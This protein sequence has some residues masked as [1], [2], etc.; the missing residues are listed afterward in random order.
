M[1]HCRV[2]MQDS[3]SLLFLLSFLSFSFSL[4]LSTI[5]IDIAKMIVL[6]LEGSANKIGIGIISDTT[7]L[8]NVRRTF[9]PP[10]GQGFLPKETAAHH[11]AH[12]LALI[13]AALQEAKI[14][15]T[16]ID[17]I[18]YTKGKSRN[19]LFLFF[20][21]PPTLP[22]ALVFAFAFAFAF[23]ANSSSIW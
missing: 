3:H 4:F 16:R 9:I 18:A 23:D 19:V 12:I 20:F 15:P 11:R 10:T 5:V 7:I 22:F 17:C 2:H 1:C 6:G 8:T 21:Q 13:K 14:D